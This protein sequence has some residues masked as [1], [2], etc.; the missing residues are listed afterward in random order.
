VGWGVTRWGVGPIGDGW[1]PVIWGGRREVDCSGHPQP[2][3]V[4]PVRVS[5]GA[6]GPG[7]P[8]RDLFPSPD[9]AVY[10]EKALILVKYLINGETIVQ[11][12]VERVTYHRLE[13]VEHNVLLAQGL[14]AESFLDLRDG[15]KYSN[16]PGLARSYPDCSA[17]MWRR[18]AV[19][20]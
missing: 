7:R 16:R 17:R 15:S 3:K 19:R 6:S 12:P 20:C 5:A 18:L 10:V 4:W 1:A 11:L 2:R 8:H 13:L 9:H 14:P